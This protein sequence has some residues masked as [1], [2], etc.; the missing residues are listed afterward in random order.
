MVRLPGRAPEDVV[1]DADGNVW[2]GLDDGRL[3]RVAS[4]G[5]EVQVVAD[6]GGRPLGLAVCR[7]GR[8]LICDSQRGLLRCDPSTGEIE[9]LVTHV[10]GRRLVFC[11]NVIE[12]VDGTIYFTESTNGF[13]YHN[14]KGAVLE[15]RPTGSLF[16]RDTDGTIDV[17]ASGLQFA[18][19]VAL[20]ADESAVVFAETMGC[21]LSKYWLTGTRAGSITELVSELPGYPDNIGI[22]SDGRVWAALV[23]GRNRLNE[24]LGPRAPVLRKTIWRLPYRWL[25][26][27]KPTVWAAA[28][29][30]DDGR[31]LGQLY[32]VHAAFGLVTGV[33][34]AQGRL[35]LGCIG[36]AAL[37]YVDL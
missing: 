9:T 27:P 15:G 25:P 29:H 34:E 13:G 14:Y 1:V 16:R 32:T 37:G 10:A 35:W 24:W 26:D 33:A 31:V 18:N 6:T 19:G 5:A 2:T 7:D 23:S 17:L 4:D 20:T 22:G 36:A 21:R 30:P 8:L 28:F 11:S 12:S 3:L